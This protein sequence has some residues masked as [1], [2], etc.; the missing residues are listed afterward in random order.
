MSGLRPVIRELREAAVKGGAHAKDRLHHLADNLDDHLDTVIRRVK[1]KDNFD[2]KPG[3]VKEF[4]TGSYKDLKKGEVVGDGLQHD[5]IPSSAAVIRARENELGEKLTPAQ[6]RAVHNDAAA[7]EISDLLHS[8]SRTFRGRNTPAQ[9]EMDATDLRGAM[10]RDLRTL[11][12]NLQTEGRLSPERIDTVI[13]SIRDL[14][15]K[16]GIG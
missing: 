3:P 16:R 7:V 6:R 13:Q 12:G 8:Q 14:N 2:G 11:R 4:D 5:H 10:E 9:I 15:L 1:D